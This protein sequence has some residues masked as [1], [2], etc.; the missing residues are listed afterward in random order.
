ML[1]APGGEARGK[2]KSR[3]RLIRGHSPNLGFIP[4]VRRPMNY[5]RLRPPAAHTGVAQKMIKLTERQLEAAAK[6]GPKPFEVVVGPTPGLR[7]SVQPSGAMSWCLRYRA[8]GR[9]RKLVFARYP[10]LP[11]PEARKVAAGLYGQVASGRDPGAERKSS[12]R[13]E[14]EAKAPV[15]DTIEKVARQYLKHAAARTRASTAAEASRI[16]RVYVLP[17]WKGK[18]LSEIDKGTVRSLIADIAGRAP[19]MA[20]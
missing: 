5:F 11:L 12:R 14:A 9:G 17:A 7:L 15:R 1:L 20:N 2:Q 6:P 13:R 10:G 19:I 8:N 4:R 16:L 18:R 3:F